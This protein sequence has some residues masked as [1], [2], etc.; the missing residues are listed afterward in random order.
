MRVWHVHYCGWANFVHWQRLS[1]W[2]LGPCGAVIRSIGELLWHS[3][4]PRLFRAGWTGKRCVF[5]LRSVP[6]GNVHVFDSASCLYRQSLRCRNVGPCWL[7]FGQRSELF[8]RRS[9]PQRNLRA[10]RAV[11]CNRSNVPWDA[12][13]TRHVGPR[14]TDI[15]LERNLHG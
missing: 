9:L 11:E 10:P 2:D 13:F 4:R 5:I 8:V 12:V 15:C 3:L 1:T 7:N 14:R 6:V